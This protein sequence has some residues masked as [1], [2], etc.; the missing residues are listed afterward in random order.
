MIVDF[1]QEWFIQAMLGLVGLMPGTD[2]QLEEALGTATLHLGIILDTLEPF[3]IVIPF[4]T[5]FQAAGVAI[6]AVTIQIG[7]RIVRILLSL[8]TLGGGM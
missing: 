1:M 7:V 8:V 3:E 5:F 6:T 4:S 2:S